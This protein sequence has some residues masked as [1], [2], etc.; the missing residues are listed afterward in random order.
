MHYPYQTYQYD[1]IALALH[2]PV[3]ISDV[4]K[5]VIISGCS[6]TPAPYKLTLYGVYTAIPC[7][8]PM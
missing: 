2:V 5:F 8:Y 1:Y 7:Y 3:N 6:T 4:A